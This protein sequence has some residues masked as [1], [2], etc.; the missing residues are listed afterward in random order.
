MPQKSRKLLKRLAFLIHGIIPASLQA[1]QILQKLLLR[2]NGKITADYF[3][4]FALVPGWFHGFV[5]LFILFCLAV[6]QLSGITIPVDHLFR[7]V[8]IKILL[9]QYPG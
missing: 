4:Y 9:L 1:R 6:R 2:V 7:I 5:H 3:L 8:K